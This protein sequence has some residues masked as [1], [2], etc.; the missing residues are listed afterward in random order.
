MWY[1]GGSTG[2][3]R[4]GST[5]LF[6]HP[7]TFRPCSLQGGGLL[8]VSLAKSVFAQ[9]ESGECPGCLGSRTLGV[10]LETPKQRPTE[11]VAPSWGIVLFGQGDQ[12]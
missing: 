5:L 11:G 7:Y 3:E 12:A 2:S 10:R 9:G 6:T 4:R 1:P 8:G